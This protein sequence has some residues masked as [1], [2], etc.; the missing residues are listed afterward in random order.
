LIKT[1]AG[2]LEVH[3]VHISYTVEIDGFWSYA[4]NKKNRRLTWYAIGRK[5]GLIVKGKRD[6]ETCAKLLQ[7][8]ECFPIRS[9][10]T[11]NWESY[12]S[13]LPVD[14]HFIGKTNT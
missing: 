3:D 4:G 9:Y 8:M 10:S 1:E 7:K 14:K 11:D 13:L 6:N 5:S 12:S 2:T